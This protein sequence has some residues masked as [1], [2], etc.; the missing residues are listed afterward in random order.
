MGPVGVLISGAY[1]FNALDG[2]GEDAVAHEIQDACQGHPEP[3]GAYHYHNLTSCLADSA[4]SNQHSA[5]E[6][7]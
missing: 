5:G 4:A 1:L 6:P 7:G 2:R 3:Q